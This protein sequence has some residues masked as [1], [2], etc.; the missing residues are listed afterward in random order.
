MFCHGNDM[1]HPK[2]SVRI[3][4]VRFWMYFRD[5]YLLAKSSQ[6]GMRWNMQTNQTMIGRRTTTPLWIPEFLGRRN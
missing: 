1:L 5:Q 4:L 3:E 6:S 2:P